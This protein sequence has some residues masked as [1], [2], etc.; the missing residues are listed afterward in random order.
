M[1]GGWQESH[2][3]YSLQEDERRVLPRARS[4]EGL[5]EL[6]YQCWSEDERMHE[7]DM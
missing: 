4:Q 1:Q 3:V 2:P 6:P 7:A 5:L